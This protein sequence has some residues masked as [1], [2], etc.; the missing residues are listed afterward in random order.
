[1]S[2]V[3]FSKKLGRRAF[4][5]Q[6]ESSARARSTIDSAQRYFRP[7]EESCRRRGVADIVAAIYARL[8]RELP[9]ADN[10]RGFQSARGRLRCA[11]IFTLS[12]V[13][14]EDTPC[15][16]AAGLQRDFLALLPFM[17]D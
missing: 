10:E 4:L 3:V 12:A 16:F 15:I 14:H 7:G 8:C 11:A 13:R 5:A 9:R 2:L 1:M 17:R 6:H